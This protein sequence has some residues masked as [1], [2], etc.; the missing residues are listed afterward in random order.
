MLEGDLFFSKPE[1]G[2]LVSAM[3]DTKLIKINFYDLVAHKLKQFVWTGPIPEEISKV[4]LR[5]VALNR[6]VV[7]FYCGSQRIL[8][9]ANISDGKFFC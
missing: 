6:S 9:A 7:I 3:K 4:P 5:I 2:I 8:T 1:E